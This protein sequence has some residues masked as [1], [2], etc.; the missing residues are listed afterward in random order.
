MARTR[1]NKIAHPATYFYFV[2]SFFFIFLQP[3]KT[4]QPT[5]LLRTFTMATRRQW[6]PRASAHGKAHSQARLDIGVAAVILKHVDYI[7]QGSCVHVNTSAR[8]RMPDGRRLNVKQYWW[9]HVLGVTEYKTDA[10]MERTCARRAGMVC[11]N[12]AHILCKRTGESLAD[13]LTRTLEQHKKQ[14]KRVGDITEETLWRRNPCAVEEIVFAEEDLPSCME[15]TA[16]APRV[17]DYFCLRTKSSS[18][19]LTDCVPPETIR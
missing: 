4:K 2:L 5:E 8:V 7:H 13:V 14:Q 15:D 10:S 16:C 11:M 18:N 9:R 1:I 17:L 19:T 3:T 6:A 12:P